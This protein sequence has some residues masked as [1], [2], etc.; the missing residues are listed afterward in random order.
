MR[1]FLSFV[2]LLSS[3]AHAAPLAGKVQSAGKPVA[4]AYVA[5]LDPGFA[6]I[7]SAITDN[8]GAFRLSEQARDGYLV[9]QPPPVEGAGGMKVHAAQPRIFQIDP[10]SADL[11]L[12]T[13]PGS[14]WVLEA[15]S[16]DGALM[17]WE[18]FQ[19]NGV[20]GGQFLYA[21][22]LQDE[23][24]PATVWPA[25]GKLTGS[26][27]G[28]REKGLPSVLVAPGEAV[29]INIMFWPVHDYGK[30]MVKADG[31][32]AGFKIAKAGQSQLL[33]LNLELA[34]TA[35]ADL[36]RRAPEYPDGA[37][38]QIAE[39]EQAL[40]KAEQL[41][42]RPAQAKAADAVLGKALRLR[43]ELEL[44][45]AKTEI[46][47]VR[48]G[49]LAVK[50]EGKEGTDWTKYEV[51]LKQTK[52]DFRFGVFEGSPYNA[53]A[54]KAARDAG[55]ELATVLMGWNWTQSPAA[56]KAQIDQVFGVSALKKLGYDVKAHGVIWMQ[57]HEILPEQAFKMGPAELPQEALAHQQALMEQF[58]DDIDIWEAMNEPANT[59]VVKLPREAMMDLVG[60]AAENIAA[61]KK[62]ALVNSP[63][64]FSY[65]AKYIIYGTDNQPV[66]DYPQ[67]FST[68][69]RAAK[70][71]G[72]LD[73]V[74]ILGLQVYPG[75]HLN[76]EFGEQQGPAYTPAYMLDTLD[77]YREFGKNL[78]ITEFSIP[79][80]YARDWVSGYWREEWTEQTQAD[81]AEA[82]YTLAFAHP[83]V[84]S[85]GWWDVLDTKPSILTGGLL[86]PTGKPKP[87][88]E[89]LSALLKEWRTDTSV[90]VGADGTVAIPAFGGEYAVEVTG[91]GGF[92]KAETA[93]VRERWT[94]PVVVAVEKE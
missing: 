15:Y 9:V 41:Q 33:L 69:V 14:T 36:R 71:K 72:V 83:Y 26:E 90:S 82:L 77:R 11:A 87:V 39:L 62:P 42:D 16:P 30:L 81:Y 1:L 6:P 79:S 25:H 40:A 63:H 46:Q 58:E 66:D 22:N 92:K 44:A 80:S 29:A 86:S 10:K 43:D 18:D 4:A 32:G 49:T 55:F 48:K 38:V 47:R 28:P 31:A 74:Q 59:N 7:T 60:K 3:V 12:E 73:D 50:L 84:Q 5:L 2:F 23:C 68:F 78:H 75:F 52:R 76:K 65:G 19:K 35:V 57:A 64:E 85:V 34:R 27:G 20:H 91:P 21:V 53:R 93:H 37:E 51:S 8:S 54:F 88:F 61:Q 17:R 45:W 89:R 67:T 13:P 24:I 70:Q 56:K 94:T